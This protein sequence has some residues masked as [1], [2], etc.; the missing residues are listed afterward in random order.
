MPSVATIGQASALPARRASA[1]A[2]PSPTPSSAPSPRLPDRI[3]HAIARLLTSIKPWALELQSAERDLLAKIIG[4][5]DRREPGQPIAVGRQT[6]A[7]RLGVSRPTVQ[8][9]LSRLEQLGWIERDQVK[10]R[11]WGFQT[12]TINLTTQAVSRLFD[13]ETVAANDSE[14]ADSAQAVSATNHAYQDSGIQC[15]H[16]QPRGSLSY[17][18]KGSPGQSNEWS[19]KNGRPWT[20]R[21]PESLGGLVKDGISATGICKLMKEARQRGHRL[22]DIVQ[23]AAEGIRKARNPFAYLRALIHQP[24]DWSVAMRR[25]EEEVNQTKAESAVVKRRN[26]AYEWL[27]GVD[28]RMLAEMGSN[29]TVSVFGRVA[30]LHQTNPDGTRTNLGAQ[31]LTLEA[32]EVMRRRFEAGELCWGGLA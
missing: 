11:R 3:A 27:K 17:P 28:G 13:T 32:I 18:Q 29:R 14:G 19:S 15:L 9:L 25:R 10:S 7:D 12:G 22:D 20:P 4:L 30:I 31:P 6:L 1:S 23:A 26:E 8:R 2:E 5:A 24:R 16:R 21:L